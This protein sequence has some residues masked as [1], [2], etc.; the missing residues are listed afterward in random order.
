MLEPV[1]DITTSLQ[2][3]F[4]YGKSMLPK[5]KGTLQTLQKTFSGGKPENHYHY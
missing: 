4:G 5:A 1:A 2:C 3:C